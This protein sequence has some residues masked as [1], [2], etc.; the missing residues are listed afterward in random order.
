MLSQPLCC[1]RSLCPSPRRCQGARMLRI[2]MVLHP[3]PH[4]AAATAFPSENPPKSPPNLPPGFPSTPCPMSPPET[5]LA[6]PQP[7][8]VPLPRDQWDLSRAVPSPCSRS[9]AGYSPK[10]NPQNQSWLQL[11]RLR[12][13]T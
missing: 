4:P 9:R 5:I 2:T 1:P 8:L 11:Y 7:T 13:G 10:A 12:R 3:G 6:A